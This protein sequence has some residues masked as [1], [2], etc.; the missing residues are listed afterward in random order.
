M[1]LN[2]KKERKMTEIFTKIYKVIHSCATSD[3]LYYAL[4]YLKLAQ[5]KGYI[6]E[7]FRQAIY[8]SVYLDKEHE[9]KFK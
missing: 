8:F 2:S 1:F 5:E 3:Q 6:S 4:R 9:L 7:E